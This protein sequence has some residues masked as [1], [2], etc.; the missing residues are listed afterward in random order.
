MADI[1]ISYARKERDRCIA[2]Y[3]KLVALE[4]DVWFDAKLENGDSLSDE[5]NYQVRESKCVLVLWSPLSVESQWV[6]SE[7]LIK[8]FEK[9]LIQAIIEKVDLRVPFNGTHYN[10]LT[11]F[12]GNDDH[13]EWI[14][15]LEKIGE[16]T[17]RKGIVQYVNNLVNKDVIAAK[18]WAIENFDDPLARNAIVN[19]AQLMQQET[20]KD[21]NDLIKPNHY[22]EDHTKTSFKINDDEYQNWEAIKN[23]ED[24][25]DFSDHLKHWPNGEYAEQCKIRFN[26]LSQ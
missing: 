24:Y 2:I 18:R 9:K 8:F 10:D 14:K 5:I 6:Q 16:F 7:A 3:D 20:L 26:E 17:N 1:F 15:V 4:L 23:S 12:N 11:N 25:R 19:T 22:T 21:I 13:E